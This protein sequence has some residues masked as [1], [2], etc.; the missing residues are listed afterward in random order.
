MYVAC[1]R[2]YCTDVKVD[3]SIGTID[4]DSLLVSDEYIFVQVKETILLPICWQNITF[5]LLDYVI[6]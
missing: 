1:A 3:R 4:Y 5:C 6:M 2:P